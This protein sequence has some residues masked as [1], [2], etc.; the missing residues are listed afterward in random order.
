MNFFHTMSLFWK[1]PFINPWD[2]VWRH[3]L[4][5]GRKILNLFPTNIHREKFEVRVAN[6][7][8]ANGTGALAGTQRIT[9]LGRLDFR[10]A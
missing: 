9:S 2:A 5:Q 3:T 8:V 7:A 6:R 1:N 4:W 10:S